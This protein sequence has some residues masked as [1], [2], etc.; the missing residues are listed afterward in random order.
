M[1]L[2][3]WMRRLEEREDRQRQERIERHLAEIAGAQS[4]ASPDEL[5]DAREADEQTKREILHFQVLAVRYGLVDELMRVV[6]SA[7][8]GLPNSAKRSSNEIHGGNMYPVYGELLTKFRPIVQD[9]IKAFERLLS[10][11]SP[12]A[13]NPFAEVTITYLAKRALHT[14]TFP[15]AQ[16]ANGKLELK[17]QY[18][19]LGNAVFDEGDGERVV[20]LYQAETI[21]NK[22]LLAASFPAAG[23]AWHNG[24]AAI[25]ALYTAAASLADNFP[26]MRYSVIGVNKQSFAEVAV[27]I[28]ATSPEAARVK[29]DLQGIAPVAVVPLG[30]EPATD[31]PSSEAPPPKE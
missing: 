30:V 3:E 11:L 24:V 28:E 25:Y 12:R 31:H 14:L 22:H 26:R 5:R 9:R 16:T 7:L 17:V 27:V 8:D 18:E 20:A 29:A 10:Q 2:P 15:A 23:E 4:R 13:V 6:V 1:A 21:K 19:L